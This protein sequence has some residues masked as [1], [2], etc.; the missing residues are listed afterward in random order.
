MID[1]VC[2]VDAKYN[3]GNPTTYSYAENRAA[4]QTFPSLAFQIFL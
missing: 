1:S 2:P 4:S 3:E